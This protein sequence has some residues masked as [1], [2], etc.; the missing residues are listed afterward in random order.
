MNRAGE[1][2]KGD[3]GGRS[4]CYHVEAGSD[5]EGLHGL[6]VYECVIAFESVFHLPGLENPGYTAEHPGIFLS[7][8]PASEA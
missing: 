1:W 6:K 8:V 5:R 4:Y 3:D 7:F 2:N